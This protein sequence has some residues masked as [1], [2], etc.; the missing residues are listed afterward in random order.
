[1]SFVLDASVAISWALADEAYPLADIALLQLEKLGSAIAPAIFWYELR[2]ILVL[3]ERRGRIAP[4]DADQFLSKVGRLHIE[5][6]FPGES[7]SVVSLARKHSLSV[8]DSAYLALALREH[9]PLA[10]LDKYLQS[11]AV[12]EGIALLA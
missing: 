4:V 12:A 2:N 10:T 6:E 5:I 8:Y 1:M 9:L 11:A 7:A 3:N